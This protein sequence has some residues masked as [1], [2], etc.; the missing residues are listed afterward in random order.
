M[1]NSS[2]L[3]TLTTPALSG[4]EQLAGHDK[5]LL[6]AVLAEEAERSSTHIQL[7]REAARSIEAQHH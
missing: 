1:F 4:E 5:H 2:H 6:L 3:L 7:P